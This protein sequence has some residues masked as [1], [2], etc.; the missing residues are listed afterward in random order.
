M[1]DEF[2]YN[3][4]WGSEAAA[5]QAYNDACEL[6]KQKKGVLEHKEGSPCT[7]RAGRKYYSDPSCWPRYIVSWENATPASL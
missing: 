4:L 3:D 6:C 2:P 5:Y 7:N 1:H